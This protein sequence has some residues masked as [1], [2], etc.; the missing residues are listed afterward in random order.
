[1]GLAAQIARIRT[2]PAALARGVA[3]LMFGLSAALSALSLDKARIQHWEKLF[4][5]S[6]SVKPW[7][8]SIEHT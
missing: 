4:P 7:M 3:R 1:M 6:G 5:A 8:L 2:D